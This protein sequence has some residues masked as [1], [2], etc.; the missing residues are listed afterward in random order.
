MKY[1]RVYALDANNGLLAVSYGAPPT[2][3]P[4]INTLPVGQTAYTNVPVLSFSVGASGSLPLYYQWQFSLTTN[5]AGFS[6]IVLGTNS[7]Y[8]LNYPPLNT[9]GYYRVIVR[10]VAGFAT[11]APPVLLTLLVPTTSVVVT[12]LW[13]L[14]AG[15]LSFLDGSTYNTRGLAYDT[16][17]A[18]L[19][20]ADHL[21]IHLLAATNGS[22]LGDLNVAGVFN[23]GF[24]SWLFD[25]VGVADDGTLYAG[26]LT[27]TGAGFS[28][29]TWA[30]G[31]TVGS[32]AIGY[33]YG[34]GIGADPSG[35]GDRWGDTMA[36]RGSG[37]NTEIIIGSYNNTNVVLFTTPDGTTFT[38]NVINV[39]GVPLGFSGQ[40]I[41]F[42][43]G[44]TFY[45]KSPGYNGRRVAFNRATW[46]GSVTNLYGTMPSD[47]GG[48]GVD[49]AANILGGVNF[50]NTPDDLQLY[51][52]S[53]NANPPSLFSQ[54][55]F[56]SNNANVQEN[57]VT[58]LKGGLGFALD[59]NNGIV[60]ISYG[61]PVAPS[62]TLTSVAYAPGSV[63]LNWNNTYNGHGYQ[64]QY[65]NNLLD[66]SWTNVGSPVVATAATA[67]YTDTSASGATRFYRVVS[68]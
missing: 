19:A 61:I 57:S 60:A 40:G 51:L 29:A 11:S 38:P 36:V 18:T 49:V 41:A 14:P 24:S 58:T 20:V 13:T 47:F 43:D 39:T 54:T 30:P 27:L 1:P 56:G 48:I 35:T 23:G 65:K 66:V 42:G 25:Q 22:Y 44:D 17:S 8:T 59:V 31:F 37:T 4:T 7:S 15:S 26:N 6:N 21:N 33:A 52:L 2:T 32:G 12:Q 5:N 10:N 53:G 68:Q 3:A 62:V 63:T 34:G 16:N 45:T 9:A 64:V 67:S 46:T 50:G 28:I 55:F